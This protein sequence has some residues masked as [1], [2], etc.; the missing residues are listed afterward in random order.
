MARLYRGP[1]PELVLGEGTK[2]R[3]L[4]PKGG[5]ASMAFTM[6]VIAAKRFALFKKIVAGARVP[7]TG[8]L[9]MDIQT[10][11]G[12]LLE[13]FRM[14]GVVSESSPITPRMLEACWKAMDKSTIWTA[15][16]AYVSLQEAKASIE[17]RLGAVLAGPDLVEIEE[18]EEEEKESSLQRLRRWREEE[19]EKEEGG[20]E[21]GIGQWRRT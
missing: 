12:Q 5:K 16:Y 6:N 18:E 3:V 9:R 4:G 1:V 10:L 14:K 15:E 2:V 17:R 8:A 7:G 11:N 21:G 19:M 13:A 20:D